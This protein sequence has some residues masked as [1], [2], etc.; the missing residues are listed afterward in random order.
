[1]SSFKAHYTAD[2]N[3]KVMRLAVTP[4]PVEL[5]PRE[6]A[7]PYI[8]AALREY[9]GLH[10]NIRLRK[11][12]AEDRSTEIFE[13][14]TAGLSHI[15]RMRKMRTVQP[16]LC[17]PRNDWMQH[18]NWSLNKQMTSY[19]I[20]IRSKMQQCLRE[21][22]MCFDAIGRSG[23]IVQL[24]GEQL[25]I[26]SDNIASAFKAFR[27]CIMVLSGHADKEE[28]NTFPSLMHFFPKV[29]IK[30]MFDS[31]EGLDSAA[32]AVR[33]M[34][35]ELISHLAKGAVS[36]HKSNAHKQ[37]AD[38]IDAAMQFDAHLN[39]HLGEEEELAVPMSLVAPDALHKS[40]PFSPEI[41]GQDFM[42]QQMAHWSRDPESTLGPKR[43]SRL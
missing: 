6:P 37:L 8:K 18:E 12:L 14:Y 43:Q 16:E 4:S 7:V 2:P 21:L 13:N 36:T 20:P 31:H 3:S 32:E 35:S 17:I 33:D 24:G 40:W 41:E 27:M 5:S 25:E 11:L 38:L 34:F 28:H 9:I 42:K 19:H 23:E 1:M 29:D 10:T 39:Q 22:V 15:T 30:D 26:M